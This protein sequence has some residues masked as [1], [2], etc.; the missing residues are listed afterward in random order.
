M[1]GVVSIHVSTTTTFEVEVDLSGSYAPG[2]AAT[3]EEP[4][5]DGEV[6]DCD[7][8]GVFALRSVKKPDGYGGW[9][10][11]RFDI[12]KGLDKA[13]RAQIAANILAFLGDE[14]DELITA[15]AHS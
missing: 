11:D 5:S 12:L 14:A 15:E 7:V 13:A 10:W 8:E 1:G 4:G 2:Y 9:T 3:L 6:D